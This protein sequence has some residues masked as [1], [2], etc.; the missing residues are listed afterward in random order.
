V[1]RRITT[2]DD[3]YRSFVIFHLLFIFNELESFLSVTFDL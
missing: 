2:A 1:L 3:G